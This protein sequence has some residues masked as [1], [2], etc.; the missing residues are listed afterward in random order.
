MTRT[1]LTTLLTTLLPGMAYE[2]KGN[3]WVITDPT[4][5]RTFLLNPTV[6]WEEAMIVLNHWKKDL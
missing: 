4:T 1:E 6:T 5:T 2:P 3:S